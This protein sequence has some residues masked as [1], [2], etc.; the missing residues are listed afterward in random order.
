MEERKKRFSTDTISLQANV[1]VQFV[2][3][4][5]C[6]DTIVVAT[7]RTFIALLR[8]CFQLSAQNGTI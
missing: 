5:L 4:L 6:S 8:N 3:T 2:H 7:K 1:L